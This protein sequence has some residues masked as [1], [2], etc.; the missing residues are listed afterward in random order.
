VRWQTHAGHTGGFG[1]CGL[2]ADDGVGNAEAR[3]AVI[4]DLL[5][6]MWEWTWS[7]E[8][9]AMWWRGSVHETG[10]TPG[11][12]SACVSGR[13]GG[14]GSTCGC[15]P[16]TDPHQS[17]AEIQPPVNSGTRHRHMNLSCTDLSRR[18]PSTPQCKF[19]QHR[20]QKW[21]T[22]RRHHRNLGGV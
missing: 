4:T 17:K 7:C 16:Y 15:A 10:S 8:R 11:W 21:C 6:W 14:D 19:R 1:A 18:S 2:E 13:E 20:H 12:M 22:G 9:D 3:R 5:G